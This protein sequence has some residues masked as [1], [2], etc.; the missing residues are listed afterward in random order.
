[1]ETVKLVIEL[2]KELYDQID[3]PVNDEDLLRYIIK[4][5]KLLPKDHG[6]LI[7][8]NDLRFELELNRQLNEVI[9]NIIAQTQTIIAAERS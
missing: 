7:D 5:G 2:P 6:R 1:M 3:K 9:D 4:Q 8:V